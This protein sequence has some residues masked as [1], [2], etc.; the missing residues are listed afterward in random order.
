MSRRRTLPSFDLKTQIAFASP[1]SSITSSHSQI[2]A[3]RRSASALVS[4]YIIFLLPHL[5]GSIRMRRARTSGLT[6]WPP[7][8]LRAARAAFDA[9][10]FGASRDQ[11]VCAAL[12]IG[13]KGCAGRVTIGNKGRGVGP[14]WSRVQP[15]CRSYVS[16]RFVLV[17]KSSTPCV[18][19]YYLHR[20]PR[21]DWQACRY[22]DRT[23]AS[24]SFE[25]ELYWLK[26][27]Q[28]C[29]P[30]PVCTSRAQCSSLRVDWSVTYLSR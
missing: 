28:L 18:A 4:S 5:R 14:V 13:G 10:A 24:S 2:P 11:A 26:R 16:I 27:L 20:L 6:G 9:L 7:D 1:F 8:C 15:C 25:P 29:A 12:G 21:N 22:W 19:R 17:M 30:L 3:A 23:S